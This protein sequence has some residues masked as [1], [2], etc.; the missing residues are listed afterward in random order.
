MRQTI[1]EFRSP[2]SHSARARLQH[3]CDD[4]EDIHHIEIDAVFRGDA[5]LDET[6]DAVVVLASEALVNAAKHSGADTVDLYAEFD[7][8]RIQLFIRDRGRGFD[9]A[10]VSDGHGLAKRAAAIGATASVSSQPGSGTEVE[11]LW[12]QQ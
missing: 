4:V 9:P 11:I 6:R 2:F 3:L 12:E 10:N 5:A 7:D 8:V 1:S